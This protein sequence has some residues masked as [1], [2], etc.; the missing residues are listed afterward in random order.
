MTYLCQSVYTTF[1]LIH[2]ALYTHTYLF[3]IAE[4]NIRNLSMLGLF[5]KWTSWDGIYFCLKYV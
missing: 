3:L 5:V 4:L 1:F 2:D